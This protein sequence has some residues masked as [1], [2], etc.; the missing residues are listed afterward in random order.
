M[1]KLSI[2]AFLIIFLL[3]NTSRLIA[4]EPAAIDSMK[5][6]LAKATD[7]EEK[8]YWYDNL[9]RT[10]MNVNPAA[11]DSIGEK[12]ILFAEES[13]D[14]KL[15]FNAYMSNGLR[16][17]YFRGQKAFL[18]RSVGYYEKALAIAKQNKMEKRTGAA[19]L[20]LADV[21]LAIPDKEEALKYVAEAF[22]RISNLKDDSLRVESNNIYGKVYLAMNYKK[23]SLQ[24]YLTA[25]ELAEEIKA[26]NA[27][28][29]RLKSELM[30]NCYIYLGS[31]YTSIENYDKAIDNYT[32]AYK[33]LDNMTD[34]RI[35]YQRCI[36]INTIGN[37][38]AQKKN[39]DIAIGY[40]ER[41]I[42]MADSLKFATLKLPGYISLLNQYLRMDQPGKALN[43][44]NS[45]AGQNLKEYLSTFR[46]TGM[47]DQAY[48]YV[49]TEL[50]K[51]D[52]ARKYFD[53]ALPYFEATMNDNNKVGIY[54]QL[55]KLFTRTGET[56]KAIENYLKAKEMGERNGLLE[57][58][59]MAA[60][61]LDSLYEDKGDFR[62]ANLYNGMYYQYKDSIQKQNKVK[63]LEQVEAE[64]EQQRQERIRLEQEELKRRR[65]NIQYMAIIIGIF[66]LFVALVILGMFKISAGWIK[67]IGFFVFLMLFEFIFLV[68]K[69]NIYSITHGEPWKDLLFMIALAAM[70]VPLHHWLEHRVMHY[71]TSHN[72]LTSAGHHIKNKFFRRTKQE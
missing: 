60:Q 34:R 33:M 71:L 67:A 40:F 17:S 44:L 45:N 29:K 10:M 41:S 57:V 1:K 52:S 24:H 21:H 19:L 50:G 66:I 25:L 6:A 51:Y 9:S 27:E 69:K 62:T 37:L 32:L 30:R 26:D 63:E 18:K 38:F 59:M 61:Y 43:Y 58:T 15:M 39:Y 48:A 13:R 23:P 22:S 7:P 49:Y 70:L 47:I 8:A 31:F 3:I 20:Q 4:Q 36:D 42:K 72:R 28:K 16:C 68:F 54:L 2:R 46:M 12:L 35:P 64:A 11:A 53:K 56:S 14:R 55:G 65:I 5:M